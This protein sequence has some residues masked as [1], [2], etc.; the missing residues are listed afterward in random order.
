MTE[1]IK[2]IAIAASQY[3][4]ETEVRLVFTFDTTASADDFMDI[5]GHAIED[6]EITVGQIKFP[7]VPVIREVR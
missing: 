3:V 2:N 4:G 7:A 1:K 6:G 5:L